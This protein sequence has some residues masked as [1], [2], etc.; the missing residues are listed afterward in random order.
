[1]KR[2]ERVHMYKK[3]KKSCNAL[4]LKENY[5]LVK[6]K[7]ISVHVNNNIMCVSVCVC[8]CLLLYVTLNFDLHM[9]H[10]LSAK[11]LTFLYDVATI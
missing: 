8:T 1:M 6:E 11:P 9:L 10:Q 7:H 2:S 3:M 5:T 4:N